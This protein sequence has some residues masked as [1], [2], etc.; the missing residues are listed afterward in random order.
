MI[1]RTQFDP[2]A[3]PVLSRADLS[4][5]IGHSHVFNAETKQRLAETLEQMAELCAVLTK[6]LT[7]VYPPDD[8]PACRGSHKTRRDIAKLEDCKAEMKAWHTHAQSVFMDFGQGSPLGPQ[9]PQT[10]DQAKFDPVQLSI[11]L[12]SMHYQ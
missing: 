6:V 12:V 5:E 11:N 1:S 7:V 3:N 8:V 2:D 9:T 10:E 4:H